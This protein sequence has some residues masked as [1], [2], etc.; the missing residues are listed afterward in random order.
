MRR[1]STP[2]LVCSIKGVDIMDIESPKVTLRQNDMVMIK[3]DFD[4]NLERNAFDLYLSEEET[5][6]FKPGLFH[7]QFEGYVGAAKV[8]S[9]IKTYDVYDSLRD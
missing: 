5:M 2:T 8:K 7:M 6:S 9:P 3:T 4:I 1:G